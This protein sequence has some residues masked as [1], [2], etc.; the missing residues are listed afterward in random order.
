MAHPLRGVRFEILS[1]GIASFLPD[2][3][4]PQQIASQNDARSAI[5]LI[6][7]QIA[8]GVDGPGC[9]IRAFVPSVE[10]CVQS[11]RVTGRIP[12]AGRA[13]PT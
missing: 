12:S 6:T 11:A 2:I 5:L 13:E 1:N 9:Q 3:N 10:S 8:A 7:S 4:T